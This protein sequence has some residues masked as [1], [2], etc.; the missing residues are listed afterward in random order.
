MGVSP[1]DWSGF[2]KD[3]WVRIALSG[4]RWTPEQVSKAQGLRP[5]SLHLGEIDEAM[6][7]SVF[8]VQAELGIGP[9]REVKWYRELRGL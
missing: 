1:S 7:C 4:P 5:D 9:A 6:G 2:A 8:E 3:P